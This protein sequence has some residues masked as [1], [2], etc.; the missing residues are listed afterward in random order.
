MHNTARQMT[1]RTRIIA[2][3]GMIGIMVAVVSFIALKF[4]NNTNQ[5]FKSYM[6]E[7]DYRAGL[8]TFVR[9]SVDRRAIAARNLVLAVKPEVIAFEKKEVMAADK[10]VQT[11]LTALKTSLSSGGLRVTD[12]AIRLV[13]EIERIETKYGVVARTIVNDALNGNKEAAIQAL[14]DQC[15]PLL[16]ALIG[17]TNNYSAYTEHF[18]D[19]MLS[20]ADLLYEKHVTL[21]FFICV[22][23]FIAAVMLGGLIARRFTMT[24]GAEPYK[25]REISRSVAD[26]DLGAVEGVTTAPPSSVLASMGNMQKNLVSLVGQVRLAADSIVRGSDEIAS[27]NTDLSARIAQQATSLRQTVTTIE[28]LTVTVQRNAENAQQAKNLVNSASEIS[29]KG[30]IVVGKVVD[31][32]HEISERSNQIAEITGLIEGIAFQTNILALNAAVEAAR[33]GEQGRGFAIVASEVRSLAQRSSSAAMEIK[34]L[35]TSSV[36][37]IRNGSALASDAGKTMEEVTTSVSR[38]TDIMGEIAVASEAQSRD[39]ASAN[40]TMT[41]ID[42]TTQKNAS[43][44][45]EAAV[46]A[47]M[48]EKQGKELIQAVGS[49]KLDDMPVVSAEPA[50]RTPTIKLEPAIKKRR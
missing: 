28:A 1:M 7:V 49:F 42:E 6:K 46:A 39:I 19:E 17:A 36:E 21:L 18:G 48:L 9:L 14:E 20:N 15:R 8:S 4:L 44:V 24:L 31:T 5:K 32:M 10:D 16:A 34:E 35:I 43:R 27:G 50:L 33:A 41:E 2:G 22:A 40:Q 12:E 25:L 13:G 37:R 23:T 38:V 47:Q 29:Q 45:K 26:G 11:Y 3:F 30:S